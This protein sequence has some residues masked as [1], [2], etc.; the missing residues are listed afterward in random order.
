MSSSLTNIL[1]FFGPLRSKDQVFSKFLHFSAFIQNQFSKTIKKF[2]CDNGTEYNNAQFHNHFSANGITFRFSCP[3]TSQ[4]NGQ[5][6]RMIRTI[7]NAVRSLL[8]QAQ[9]PNSFWVEALHIAFH[10][11]NLLPWKTIQNR[12]PYTTPFNKPT[13]YTHL[14]VFGS[15]CYPNQNNNTNHKLSNRSSPCVF[16]GYSHNH[17]GYW[18]FDLK[19]RKIIISRHV[20]FDETCFPYKQTQ[21]Q[22]DSSYDFL[23]NSSEPSPLFCQILQTPQTPLPP[24]AITDLPTQAVNPAPEAP[25]H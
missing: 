1:I 12:T 6:E 20:T 23:S 13:D 19:T 10:I 21:P 3:Y 7:N 9:L 16:F 24:P 14:R 22:P 4:Q 15:F 8:F 5:A 25:R 2:Q 17:K 11:L 18:C